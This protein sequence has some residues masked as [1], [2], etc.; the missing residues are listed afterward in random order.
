MRDLHPT[1]TWVLCVH[2]FVTCALVGLI[3][4]VQVVHYPLMLGVGADGYADYQRLHQGR[5]TLVVAPLMLTEIATA[6]ALVWLLRGVPGGSVAAW[7]GAALLA[8]VWASTFLL[9][10]PMH[11]RLGGGFDADA[12]RRLVAGNWIRTGLWTARGVIAVALLARF[13]AA[14]PRPQ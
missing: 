5:T 7:A 3:W 4:F 9:Q 11:E 1:T 2:A 6:A 13:A 10:V 12:H 8:G 14:G